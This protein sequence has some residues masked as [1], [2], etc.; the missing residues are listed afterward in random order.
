MFY[1]LFTIAVLGVI[2]IGFY[3][4]NYFDGISTTK[5]NLERIQNKWGRP[6]NARRNFKLIA[7]YLNADDSTGKMSNAIANDLDLNNIFNFIDRTNSKPGKQ[8]LY[9]RL[10]TPDTNFESLLKFDKKI[11]ALNMPRPD[12]ER[13]ELELA[14]L[15][16]AD[17]YF[18]ADLFLKE[19]ELTIVPLM[20]LYIRFSGIAIIG[21]IIS[22]FIEPYLACFMVLIALL[23][24]NI[25]LHY[26][27]R[28]KISA[29]T[30]SLPQLIILH[31]VA[32][33]LLKKLNLEQNEQVRDSL[34][35]L[36]GLNR[37]LNMVS[38]E[39]KMAANPDNFS[40]AVYKF[41]KL[42]FLL[43]PLMFISSVKR[44]NKY[45]SDIE[46]IYNYVAEID[47]LISIQSVRAGLPFYSKP[48]FYTENMQMDITDMFHPLIYNCVPNSIHTRTEE[49]VLITGS[50]MSGKTT[51][52]R[53][54]AI[55]TLLAQTLYTTCTREYKAP[56][57]KIQTSIRTTD[58][59]GENKSYFQAEALSILDIIN[60]S[61][62]AEP[63]KSLIIID[64]IFR[65][66][67]TIERIAAAKSVLTYLTDNKNFVFVSTHDL[68]LAELLDNDYAV[69]SFEESVNDTRL[70][71]DYKMKTGVLKNKNG[72]AIL[73]T[74]GYPET[75][76]EDAYIVSEELKR[77]YVL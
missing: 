9:K 18:L 55:N 60:Q 29:Y 58:D 51:F 49:G 10:F 4:Y 59:L 48:V 62:E 26:G 50:N 25:A 33:R 63:V 20:S 57:L 31:N 34:T 37:T 30:R 22:L 7:T 13:I 28:N 8:Y 76:V 67:N 40:Y 19:H 39:S 68:E 52:I 75:V 6:V 73:E 35:R 54:I 21:L 45:R 17:A 46:T 12:Q 61:S 23:I 15:N 77:K 11:D 32:K 27:V 65:G 14:K 43:E 56:L 24:G 44:I 72:I 2:L 74:I 66:T 70:V 69:Y 53:S 3:I 41:A 38:F 36:T 1:W 71:F 42:L 5:R 64:E 16:S 47:M